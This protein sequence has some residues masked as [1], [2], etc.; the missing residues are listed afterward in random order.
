MIEVMKHE[1]CTNFKICR[2][3]SAEDYIIGHLD[4]NRYIADFC[5]TSGE[6]WKTCK[7]FITKDELGFCPDFVLPDTALS[8]AEII[9]KFD[10]DENL[11]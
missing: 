8:P 9:E 11:Q 10:D 3:V 2:L 6:K 4:K 1:I 7:R 5:I